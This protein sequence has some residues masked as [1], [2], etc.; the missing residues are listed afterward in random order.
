MEKTGSRIGHG[1]GGGFGG[2]GEGES[3]DEGRGGG[4]GES[5]SSNSSTAR[6]NEGT[7][8]KTACM[9]HIR[10]S[11]SNSEALGKHSVGSKLALDPH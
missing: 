2:E 10:L 3:E 8:P 6:P 5:K 9:Q 11:N 1:V 7:V 4:E